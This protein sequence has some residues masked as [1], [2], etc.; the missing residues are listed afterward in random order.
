VY[1]KKGSGKARIPYD[2]AVEEALCYGWIDSTVKPID[3]KCYAQRFSPRRAASLL[4][5]L[6][7]ERVRGLVASGKMRRAGLEKIRHH[8]RAPRGRSAA[9]GFRLYVYPPDIIREIRKS[10]DAWK[11]FSKFPVSY[12]RVRIGWIDAARL[13]P[14]AFRQRLRYFIRMTARNKR[15][16]MI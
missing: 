2:H 9:P 10:A 12:K 6:N 7:K 11:V 14:K 16:G 8:L 1:Y 15:F 3:E 13:R 5:E 4:S